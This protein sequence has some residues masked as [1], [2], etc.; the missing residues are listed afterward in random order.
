MS[1]EGRSQYERSRATRRRALD[2]SIACLV[3]RGYHGATTGAIAAAAGV[4]RGALSHHYPTRASLFVD[5]IEHLAEERLS[6][7]ER[8]VPELTTGPDRTRSA[9]DH[10][11][12]SFSGPL[13]QAALE[14]WVEARTNDELRASLA[15]VEEA[16][17]ARISNLATKLFSPEVVEREDFEMRLLVVIDSMRGLAAVRCYQPEL[18]H[19]DRRWRQIRDVLTTLLEGP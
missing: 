19:A 8:R 17:G 13:F 11:W 12:N 16:T 5:A 2:A 14:L 6:G 18:D 15:P 9:L 1:P 7:L 10:L 4:S 3:E